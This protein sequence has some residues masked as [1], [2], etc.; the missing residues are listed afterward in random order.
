MGKKRIR[1]TLLAVIGMHFRPI[2]YKVIFCCMVCCG[3]AAYVRVGAARRG[4]A[5]RAEA[6]RCGA[7]QRGAG[8]ST[9]QGGGR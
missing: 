3:W 1:W 7:M 5:R 2:L 6:K 8:W 4:E 9:D